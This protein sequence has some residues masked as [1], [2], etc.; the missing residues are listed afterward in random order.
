MDLS[1]IDRERFSKFRNPK[2]KKLYLR[3]DYEV[4]VSFDYPML[5]YE[6]VIPRNG[7]FPDAESWG[8]DPIRKP[9]LLNCAAAIDVTRP[10]ALE[11]PTCSR[12]RLSSTAL[13]DNS[14]GMAVLMGPSLHLGES[15]TRLKRINRPGRRKSCERCR[16]RKVGCIRGPLGRPCNQCLKAGEQCISRS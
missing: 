8:D 7:Q 1:D 3:M 5:T 13:G 12:H 15:H 4:R 16:K 6:V 14:A 2:T 10:Q 11:T 9:A